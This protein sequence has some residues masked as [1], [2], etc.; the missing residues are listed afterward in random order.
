MIE[1]GEKTEEYREIKPYWIRRLCRYWDSLEDGATENKCIN[2][3]CKLALLCRRDE[4]VCTK[5]N[6]VC[7]HYGR[8]ARTMCF[9]IEGIFIGK[10]KPEWG[11]PENQK[12]VY[13]STM[14]QDR[15]IINEQTARA[16]AKAAFITEI[17]IKYPIVENSFIRQLLEAA[18]DVGWSCCQQY[19]EK[20]YG[21]PTET[22]RMQ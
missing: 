4:T 1:R 8:T 15:I 7:F 11:A 3:G 6:Y 5:Y 21:I 9:E 22:D 10:G 19:I 16:I 13:Y 18:I 20:G 14:E 2:G 12:S 17:R